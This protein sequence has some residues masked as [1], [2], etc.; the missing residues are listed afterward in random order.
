MEV[1]GKGK[2]QLADLREGLDV[3][4][5]VWD[6]LRSLVAYGSFK[7]GGDVEDDDEEEE[8]E[9]YGGI[10]R[11]VDEDEVERKGRKR[12]QRGDGRQ[13]TPERLGR[14]TVHEIAGLGKRV[15]GLWNRLMDTAGKE[16]RKEETRQWWV[17]K[18]RLSF[19]VKRVEEGLKR[20]R[21]VRREE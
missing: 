11:E 9:G 21:G 6:N 17:K 18:R 12:W 5:A 13:A 20:K 2:V 8:E 14:R 19:W 10:G 4:H 15:I 1:L 16:F 7:G 3:L